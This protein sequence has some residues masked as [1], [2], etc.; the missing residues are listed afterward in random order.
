MRRDEVTELHYITAIDNMASI[1][2]R[3]ILSHERSR[4]LRPRS[5]A[6]EAVQAR[7]ASR[8]IPRGLPLHQYANL[9]FNARNAMLYRIIN[10][11]DASKRV[12]TEDLTVLRVSADV[13]DL[14]DVVVTDLN[15]AADVAPRWYPVEDGLPGLRTEVIFS[16]RWTSYRHKQQMMAEVLVPYRVDPSYVRGAYVVSDAAAANL[17]G[18]VPTLA[19]EVNPY[20]FFRGS[21]P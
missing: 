3:G 13:L 19:V 18:V 5:V 15:A 8:R 20:M 2:E 17:S 16:E 14:P 11:Y 9:Y 6:S 21:R 1:L 10:D 7:R 12:P 4:R